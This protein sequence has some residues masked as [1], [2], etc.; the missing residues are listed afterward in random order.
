MNRT[1]II[2][3]L[4]KKIGAKKYLEIGVCRGTN[5]EQI[6]CE[7]KIGVDPSEHSPATL[8]LTSDDFFK[9]NQETFDVIF[10]DGL[11]I[12][13]QVTKDILNSLDILNEGGYI[14]CH[15]MNPWNEQ[16]QKV[17]YF[18]GE[19]TG[20]CWKSFVRLRSEREDL[21]MFVVDV[22]CGCG[23]IKQGKQTTLN[24]IEDLEYI[25]LSANRKSWLNLI[26]TKE[27]EDFIN[28]S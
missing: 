6:E 16:V 17:P 9:I 11:H 20:D 15:D 27:F 19:W 2:N 10:V 5:F 28:E 22:D 1:S 23:V 12:S 26:T 7:Y 25:N 8:R 4:I 14:V 21:E 13:E 24:I 3:A 18:G